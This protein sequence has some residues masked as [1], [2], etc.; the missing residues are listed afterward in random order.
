MNK[1][2]LQEY[3]LYAEVVGGIAV[4]I[5]LIFLVL[6]TRENTNAIQA[7]TYQSLTSEL[8]DIRIGMIDSSIPKIYIKYAKSGFSELTPVEAL[9]MYTLSQATWGVYES[10][11]FAMERGVLPSESALSVSALLHPS[12]SSAP[13][14]VT[15]SPSGFPRVM[16]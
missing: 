9:Q 13:V 14:I 2:K 10:A 11:F 4:L 6:E 5:T 16:M 15:W 3:A 7:Q 1:K 8:N 12:T